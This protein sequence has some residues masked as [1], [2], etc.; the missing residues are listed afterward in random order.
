MILIKTLGGC[1]API[2]S[3]RHG[4][5]FSGRLFKLDVANR[6][7]FIPSLVVEI[8]ANAKPQTL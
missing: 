6:A 2:Q 8:T 4:A 1:L 7:D 5:I 3:L